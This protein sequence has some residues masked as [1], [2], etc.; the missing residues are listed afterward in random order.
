M[1]AFEDIEIDT[2]NWEEVANAV[3]K[4][5]DF[6]PACKLI[7]YWSNRINQRLEFEIK[8]NKRLGYGYVGD[9]W[10]MKRDQTWALNNDQRF[11]QLCFDEKD[12]H[13]RDVGDAIYQCNHILDV[14]GNRTKYNICEFGSGYGRLAL[15]FVH[16]VG[17]NL[18]YVGIDFVPISLLI[19]GQFVNNFFD[20]YRPVLNWDQEI[21]NIEKYQFVS[22]PAWKIKEAENIKY[23]C[24]ITIHSF[25]EMAR[26]TI[27]FYIE[28]AKKTAKENSIFYS[29]NLWPEEP[30]VPSGWEL[31]HDESFPINRDGSFNEKI[32]KIK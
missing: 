11:L 19:A 29:I 32:W 9:G 3:S 10:P 23:D 16:S 14:L 18:T 24:F 30:Y 6:N 2:S 5:Y 20:G 4:F 8:N 27:D 17:W 31:I 7:N 25:Q 22:L 21:D 13:C 15:P 1:K 28:F 26:E 12:W